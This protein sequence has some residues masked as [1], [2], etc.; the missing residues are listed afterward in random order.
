LIDNI[1]NPLLM[2]GLTIFNN[3]LTIFNNGLTIFKK[4]DL[5]II[6]N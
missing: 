4:I 1:V 5:L 6:C 2:N 3:G